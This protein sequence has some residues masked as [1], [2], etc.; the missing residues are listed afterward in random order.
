MNAQHFHLGQNVPNPASSTTAIPFA[1]VHTSDVSLHIHNLQGRRIHT[2]AMSAL[3][4]GSHT[5]PLVPAELGHMHGGYV[6][7]LIVR[8]HAGTFTDVRSMMVDAVN[9]S[10]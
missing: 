6:Y 10:R 2:I 9:R 5:I 4:P 7:Q 8:N 1:L 3:A